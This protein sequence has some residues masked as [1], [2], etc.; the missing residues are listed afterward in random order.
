MRGINR[1]A[2][3][4]RLVVAVGIAQ[5]NILI[6]IDIARAFDRPP[7]GIV[8]RA[9]PDERA[10]IDA[11]LLTVR[12]AMIHEA[13]PFFRAEVVVPERIEVDVNRALIGKTVRHQIG[14]EEI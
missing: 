6:L 13:L 3:V 4:I 10:K 11:R 8:R 1:P 14:A 9:E 2:A 12:M 5:Q 7:P